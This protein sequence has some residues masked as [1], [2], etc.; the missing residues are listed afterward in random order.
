MLRFSETGELTT[1][2]PRVTVAVGREDWASW[3]ASWH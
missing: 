3:T 2:W 1:D